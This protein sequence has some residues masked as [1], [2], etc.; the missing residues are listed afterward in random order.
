MLNEARLNLLK[1]SVG[2]LASI[3]TVIGVI[4]SIFSNETVNTTETEIIVAKERISFQK[5]SVSKH[6]TAEISGIKQYV[7]GIRKKQ[8]MTIE[9]YSEF[10][11]QVIQKDGTDLEPVFK[12]DDRL[13]Y[14]IPYTGDYTI[15]LK[16]KGRATF[17]IM[18][19]PL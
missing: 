10:A 19:P 9:K 5:G 14:D 15:V 11:L 8:K 3:F 2:I 13:V 6:V 16:C 7:I 1:V 18:I 4:Y 12:T 17:N